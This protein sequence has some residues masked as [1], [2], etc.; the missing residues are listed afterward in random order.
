MRPY[1]WAFAIALVGMVIVAA[2]DTVMAYMVMP[3]IPKLERVDRMVGLD[4]G[5]G[6]EQGTQAELLAH[7][8][9]DEKLH[10]LQFGAAT[11][12]A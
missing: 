10:R 6:V 2:G 5:R 8:G 1:W 11:A 12:D 4:A 3:I 7:D 9:L